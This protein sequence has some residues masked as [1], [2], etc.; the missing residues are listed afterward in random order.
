MPN[1]VETSKTWPRVP[2]P[3]LAGG[4]RRGLLSGWGAWAV[5]LAATCKKEGQK[6]GWTRTRKDPE[7]WLHRS[8]QVKAVS[9]SRGDAKGMQ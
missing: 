1:A 4:S 7:R 9:G 3:G 6:E 5:F 2:R 8:G